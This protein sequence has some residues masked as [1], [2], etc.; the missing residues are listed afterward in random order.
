MGTFA[1]VFAKY[2]GPTPRTRLFLNGP[3][4]PV[5]A[6]PPVRCVAPPFPATPMADPSNF[7][8]LTAAAA[9]DDRRAT[10]RCRCSLDVTCTSSP[11]APAACLASVRDVSA[12]GI[13]LVTNQPFPSG[14]TLTVEL[15]LEDQ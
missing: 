12:T 1:T 8:E 6:R 3:A 9:A 10:P 5:A 7:S 15:I 2:G 11:S 13:G 4:S 14:A